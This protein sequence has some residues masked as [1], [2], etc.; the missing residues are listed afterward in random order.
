MPTYNY[1]K[2][3]QNPWKSG[4]IGTQKGK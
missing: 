3:G 2:E 4:D 1:T